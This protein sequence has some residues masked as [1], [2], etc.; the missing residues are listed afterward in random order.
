MLTDISF[1][2]RII[3]KYKHFGRYRLFAPTLVFVRESRGIHTRQI[4]RNIWMKLLLSLSKIENRGTEP[5]KA[6]K[7]QKELARM[8]VQD[9]Q[10]RNLR[11]QWETEHTKELTTIKKT[12][13]TFLRHTQI[14]EL[15][16]TAV[17]GPVWKQPQLIGQ[18]RTLAGW[19]TAHRLE[20]YYR[21][22]DAA[23]LP[24]A[25]KGEHILHTKRESV[26][27]Q[28]TEEQIVRRQVHQREEFEQAVSRVTQLE[29]RIESQE[30]V[31]RELR[32]LR[33]TTEQM[34]LR[35]NQIDS[36]TKAVVRN[37][38]RELHLEKLRRGLY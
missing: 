38:E 23:F 20:Q 7:V 19:E 16:K 8:I 33:Q 32:E 10:I 2:E 22:R 15:V 9:T 34:Q 29:E 24:Q 6:K 12:V 30:Q 21:E 31:L 1:A 17:L 28:D 14:L 36:I 11:G 4:N 35:P 3:E 18:V 37:M 27:Y 25:E 5:D 26:W 13:N